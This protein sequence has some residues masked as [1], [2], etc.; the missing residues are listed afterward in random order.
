MDNYSTCKNKK[1][2]KMCIRTEMKKTN[3]TLGDDGEQL[4]KIL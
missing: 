3:S 4:P 1:L 2:Y